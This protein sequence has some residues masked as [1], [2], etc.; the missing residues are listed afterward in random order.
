MSFGDVVVGVMQQRA[1]EM[2]LTTAMDGSAAGRSG[3]E[4][5]RQAFVERLQDVD[6]LALSLLDELREIAADWANANNALRQL[7]A[8]ELTIADKRKIE[9][10]QSGIRSHLARYGFRSFQ[11]GEISLSND[12]FRPLVLRVEQGETVE[13]EINF[14]M[15]ASDAIRLKWAYYLA[16]MELMPDFTANYAGHMIFDEPGQ[17]EVE[18]DSLFAFMR[19]ASQSADHDHQVLVSTSETYDAVNAALAGKANIVS[20]PGFILQPIGSETVS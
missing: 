8:D 19:S 6:D 2:R 18:S 11:P 5:M 16:C 20:F 12:N 15:S 1:G 17:Q 4:E 7:P 14:E 3:S 13:K 9:Y 10:L